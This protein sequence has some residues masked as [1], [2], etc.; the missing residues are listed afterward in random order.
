MKFQALGPL[1]VFRD[2]ESVDLGTHTQKSLLA[3]LLIHA[4]EVVSTNR[5]LEEI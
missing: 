4:N 1:E 3:L 5:I 2:D